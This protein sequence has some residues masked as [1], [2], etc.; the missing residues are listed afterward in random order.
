MA[1]RG[2]FVA[3]AAV[4]L[5]GCGPKPDSAPATAAAAIPIT[6]APITARAVPRLVSVVG[7]LTGFDEAVLA[8]KADGRLLRAYVDVGDTVYAG[9]PLLDLDPVDFQL[10]VREAKEALSAELAKLGLTELTAGEIDIEAVPQVRRATVAVVDAKR[11]FAQKK[12][13]FARGVGSQD[14]FDI[15]Q[16]ELQLADAS[17]AA[18]MTDARA[19]VAAA[20]LRA[21]ALATAE[22]RLVDCRLLAPVP[23]L[24]PGLAGLVGPAAVPARYVVANRMVTEGEMI[25]SMPGTNAYKLV[26]DHVLKL[27]TQVPERYA[28]DIGVGLP[29]EVRVEAYPGRVFPGRVSRIS[30]IVDPLNL[31]F[32][33]EVA[34]PN[35]S[36]LLRAGGFAKADIRIRTDPAVP[37]V[38]PEAIL[39]FAGVSKVFIVSGSTVQAQTITVGARDK[40]W[41]EIIGRVPEGANVAVAGLSQLTDGAAVR[42]R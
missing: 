24:W 13:L 4:A 5:A 6:V 19:V 29:A 25:R 2:W 22:Q 14:E 9:Q 12:D 41:V 27:R 15:A 18:A 21:A 8:P 34:V 1:R 32:A 17:K 28:P 16:T 37:T 39:N 20:R 30:P 35:F 36:G 40:D 3:A 31:T 33:V 26:L 23:S 7:T 42:L 38:P 11:K 10:A